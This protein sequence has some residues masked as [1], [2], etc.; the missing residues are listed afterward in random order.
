MIT[1]PLTMVIAV[2]PTVTLCPEVV[3]AC[4]DAVT[5]ELGSDIPRTLPTS[6]A[7]FRSGCRKSA[8]ASAAVG[9]T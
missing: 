4:S 6:F 8:R 2:S 1:F 3:V 9:K 5:S 7:P